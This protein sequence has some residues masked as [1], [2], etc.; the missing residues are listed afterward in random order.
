MSSAPT[1]AEQLANNPAVIAEQIA[2]NPSANAEPRSFLGEAAEQVG[3]FFTGI[4][5]VAYETGE[6]LASLGSSIAKTAYDLSP[7]EP[8]IDIA[9]WTAEKISGQDLQ[10]PGWMPDSECGVERIQAGAEVVGA[11]VDDPGKL[12]DAV[13]D[14]IKQD[15]NAGRHGEAIGRG[16]AEVIAVV[17]G[18][19]GIDKAAKGAKIAGAVDDV[20]KTAGTLGWQI[21]DVATAGKGVSSVGG[22]SVIEGFSVKESSIIHEARAVLQSSEMANI[23]SA[24]VAG[25][26]ATVKIGEKVIQYEPGLPASG[27]TMFGENGFLIGKE[28]FSSGDELGKTVLH[29]LHR[30]NTSASANGVSG[31]LATKETQAAFDFAQ[32]AIGEIK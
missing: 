25:Q 23:K 11:I 13:V 24:H 20:A 17:A 21:D 29:E 2:N 12:V 14:P 4:G 27:M 31:A 15:W 5:E 7:I 26:S 22:K 16:F 1:T 32:R 18:T 19:K 6:G 28:A 8:A 30:L 10:R 3:G 9:E